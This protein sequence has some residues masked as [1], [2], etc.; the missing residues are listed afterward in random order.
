MAVLPTKH[1]SPVLAS[2]REGI[3]V[4]LSGLRGGGK[5]TIAATLTRLL[6]GTGVQGVIISRT[7]FRV[8][9]FGGGTDYPAWYPRARRRRPRDDHR[10]VLLHQRPRAAAVLQPPVPRRL[11][12]RSR[13]SAR[14]PKSSTRRC[15]PCSSGS[16]HRRGPRDPPRRRSPGALG[17]RLELGVH[18]RAAST[19]CTRSPAARS[20]ARSARQ[21]GDPRRAVPASAS[22]SGSQ[23]QISAAFGGFNHVAFRQDG[24]YQVTPMILPSAAGSRRSRTI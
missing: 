8:S 2:C 3:C 18:R 15:G 21:R 10:Q 13:T 22:L 1:L 14:S 5:T 12:G 17:A 4:W 6:T 24:T 11:L 16:A 23:D 7:P 20:L 9:F 19:R